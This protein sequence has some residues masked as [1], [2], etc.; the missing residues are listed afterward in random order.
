MVAGYVSRILLCNE[1]GEEFVFTAD[2][3]QYLADRG[4]THDPR[5]CKA[6][7]ITS[8]RGPGID[9]RDFKDRM[10]S[11]DCDSETGLVP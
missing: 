8:K 5:K 10:S 6:C 11:P 7:H 9:S 1:C 3:Q 2:A 4:F